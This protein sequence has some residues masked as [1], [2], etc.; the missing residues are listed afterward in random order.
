MPIVQSNIL[1]LLASSPRQSGRQ[2][3]HTGDVLIGDVTVELPAAIA[4][5]PV[6]LT[7]G[8]SES[9]LKVDSDDV[10]LTNFIRKHYLEHF[11]HRDINGMM[12]DYTNNGV[13][14]TIIH[15]VTS[16]DNQKNGGIQEQHSKLKFH[17]KDEIRSY[18]TDLIFKV[19]NID[20]HSCTFHL[21]SITIHKNQAT[22]CW[23]AKTPTLSIIDAVDRF[24]F[25]G[26]GL[27]VKQF[28]S[29]ETHERE[30][31]VT[32]SRRLSSSSASVE[33]GS[34]YS[35]FFESEK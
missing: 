9:G 35:G 23:T 22:V 15:N 17:G 2:T 5:M 12:G 20:R 6:E 27:I 21:E 29:C 10:H 28:S 14:A 34:D 1:S 16:F 8:C 19:H 32:P 25:N 18:Y 4:V 3:I 7:N 11:G 30:N 33:S 24:V 26:Q 31:I 13:D